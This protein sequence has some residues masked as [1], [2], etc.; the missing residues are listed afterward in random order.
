MITINCLRDLR[1]YS[2][3]NGGALCLKNYSGYLLS[4]NSFPEGINHL[5]LL[6]CSELHYVTGKFPE[7]LKRLEIYNCPKICR[8]ANLVFG[9]AFQTLIVHEPEVSANPFGFGPTT[10]GI[11]NES[12]SPSPFTLL[13]I[14]DQNLMGAVVKFVRTE[15]PPNLGILP[16]PEELYI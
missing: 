12:F 11:L 3:E 16:V 5:L 10:L 15:P 6:D 8:S 9:K 1:K 13:R 7:S 4:V 14:C 2:Q